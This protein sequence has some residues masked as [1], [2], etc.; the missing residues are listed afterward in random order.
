MKS[1]FVSGLQ[2]YQKKSSL[3]LRVFSKPFKNFIDGKYIDKEEMHIDDQI[4][5]KTRHYFQDRRPR[6]SKRPGKIA[7]N[8]NIDIF[9][10]TSNQKCK[11]IIPQFYFN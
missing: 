4:E 3:R 2:I 5:D 8:W 9:F 7:T 11:N 6:I 10:G 1:G